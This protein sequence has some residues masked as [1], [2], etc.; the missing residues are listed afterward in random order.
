MATWHDAIKALNDLSLFIGKGQL[1][2]LLT[3]MGGEERQFFFDKLVEYRDRVNSMAKTYDQQGKGDDSIVYLHYFRGGMDWYIT[4]RDKEP[5]PQLQAFGY[6]D[7]HDGNA[8]WGYI[9][10]QEL[11][12]AGVEL[13]LYW[14][15]KPLKQV[16]K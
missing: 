11:I 2:A 6:A 3:A 10:I 8:E 15:P 9:S 14:E 12:E 5:G 7:W 13:D 4:E 16:K 1:S